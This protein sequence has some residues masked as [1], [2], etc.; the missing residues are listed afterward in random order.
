MIHHAYS[1]LES[2][3]E[4]PT[5][6]RLWARRWWPTSAKLASVLSTSC[7]VPMVNSSGRI[8]SAW[9]F[10]TGAKAAGADEPRGVCLS[11]K[12]AKAWSCQ[13]KQL[14]H[15]KHSLRNWHHRGPSQGPRCVF[16]S[17]HHYLVIVVIIVIIVIAIMARE[18]R[19]SSSPLTAMTSERYADDVA[20]ITIVASVVI[21]SGVCGE[22]A[23]F[24]RSRYVRHSR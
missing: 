21:R 6:I 24:S 1:T 3:I 4:H 2:F 23:K 15:Q 9:A 5:A 16:Y 10:S 14:R 19:L 7:C 8:F 11:W 17:P 18:P 22:P 13:G 20:D 12:Y